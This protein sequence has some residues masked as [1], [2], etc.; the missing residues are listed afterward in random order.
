MTFHGVAITP[1]VRA[2]WHPG[3]RLDFGNLAVGEERSISAVLLSV[4]TTALV[5]HDVR[6]EQRNQG[7]RFSYPPHG[8]IE[9]EGLL[10]FVTF[11]PAQPGLQNNKLLVET[12]AGKQELILVGK[13]V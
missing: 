11:A 6:L 7:F 1:D 2:Q 5:V 12:N 4:G 8:Q 9:S 10:L 3:D 13:G